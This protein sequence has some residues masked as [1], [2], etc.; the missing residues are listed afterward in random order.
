MER[1]LTKSVPQE[2]ILDVQVLNNSIPNFP[3]NLAKTRMLDGCHLSRIYLEL[4]QGR[5]FWIIL[6]HRTC[7][8]TLDP[9]RL[10]QIGRRSRLIVPLRC[11]RYDPCLWRAGAM[12]GQDFEITLT[13]RIVTSASNKLPARFEGPCL[14]AHS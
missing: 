1:R 11:W 6:W 12:T 8:K 2:A 9:L 14:D 3:N 10:L 4:N 5:D 7:Q 13:T